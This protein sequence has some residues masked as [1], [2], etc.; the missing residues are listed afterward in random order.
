M[1]LRNEKFVTLFSNAGF[2][3]VESAAILMQFVAAPDER[4]A[5]LAKRM[6][7]T[8]HAGVDT[9]K[10]ETSGKAWATAVDRDHVRGDQSPVACPAWL[11]PGTNNS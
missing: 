8:E 2:N 5:E 1:Q 6:H 4:W 3:V 7:A 9:T 11:R 10:G